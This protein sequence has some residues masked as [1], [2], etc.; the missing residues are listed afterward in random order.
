MFEKVIAR[1]ERIVE[2]T[3]RGRN[4]IDVDGGRRL[5]ARTEGTSDVYAIESIGLCGSGRAS[6]VLVY[7]WHHDFASSYSKKT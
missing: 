7:Y 2:G 5:P 6:L 3:I 1:I 4:T